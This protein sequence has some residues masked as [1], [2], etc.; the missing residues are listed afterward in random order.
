LREDASRANVF[1]FNADDRLDDYQ[2]LVFA[3]HGVLPGE[4]DSLT[5]PALVLSYPENDGY[6]TMADVFQL[7]LNTTLVALSACN[8]GSGERIRGEG[9]LGLTRAFMYAGTPAIA[10]TLWSVETFSA[11][12]L[13][14]G[15]FEHLSA[16]QGPVHALRSIKLQML[17]GEK[18]EQ[19][20]HLYYWA[21]FVLFGDGGF[22]IKPLIEP[23]QGA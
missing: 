7:H 23:K 1:A 4:V 13:N 16:G 5:Q 12:E 20:R 15:L 10:V 11:K 8:T 2:Y 17:H 3:T 18:G 21:P 9:V 22:P 14:V 6:L 19:Y